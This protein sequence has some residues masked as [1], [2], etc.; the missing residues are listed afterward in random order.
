M[1]SAIFTAAA[2]LASIGVIAW[3]W[4]SQVSFSRTTTAERFSQQ[5]FDFIVVGGGTAGLVAAA[6]LSEDPDVVVGIIEAGQYRPDDPVINIPNSWAAP[7]VTSGFFGNPTYDWGFVS[8]PQPG[9]NG[10]PV[11]YPRGRVVGGSSAIN[12]M[13]WQRGSKEEY[14]LWS[15]SFGNGDDW[16]FSGLL[17]YFKKVETWSPPPASPATFPVNFSDIEDAHGSSGPIQISYNNFLTD[18]EEPSVQAANL[19]G[20]P[21]NSNPDLGNPVGFSP[22]ARNVD[23]A[24]GQRMYAANSY[25]TPNAQ[26]RNLVLLTGAQATKIVFDVNNTATGVQYIVDGTTYTTH[27]KKELILAAG[28]LKTPQLLEL[29]GVG[30]KDL[31]NQLEIPCVLDLPSVG[32]NLLDHPIMVSDYVLKVP[33]IT[34]DTLRNN[35]TFRLQQQAI[36]NAS[37]QGALSFTPA[38]LAPISLQT[39]FGEDATTA[40][41]DLL[42]TSLH[43]MTQSALQTVQY[44]A[45][46]KM[47]QTGKN[48]FLELVVVPTGGVAASPAPGV[49]YTTIAVMQLHPFGRGSVHINSTDPLASPVI[50]PRFLEVPF[51]AEILIKAAQWAREWMGTAPMA[52]VVEAFDQ[53]SG[54]VNSPAAW[55]SFVR[56][57][58]QSTNHPMGTTAMA[59]RS[60][61]G[62]VDPQLK[63]YGLANVRIIDAGIFPFTISVPIQPTVYAIAEKA[64][65]MI[66]TT[67]SLS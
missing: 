52:A 8:V 11:P 16:T 32:E 55:D 31:L 54:S 59:P 19:L 37:G 48:P 56:S 41:I 2:L 18:V 49:S 67:W 66:K 38:A 5:E 64:A 20:V 57:H 51:D 58:T 15:T 63:V 22:L 60:M 24:T 27:V 28:S 4:E 34:L 23:P 14:D 40:M 7:S 25:Y 42:K 1:K 21:L 33:T 36:Y 65:D 12:A 9:L 35:A 6:R 44:D 46:L 47:L 43:G 39:L 30:S 45:Q 26:R 13:I 3:P 61:G 50:D 10:K 53:P 17:P 62:V 29:S